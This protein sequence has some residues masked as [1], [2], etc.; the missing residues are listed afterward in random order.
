MSGRETWTRIRTVPWEPITERLGQASGITRDGAEQ[1]L[2][3]LVQGGC[4][5]IGTVRERRRG[6]G[7]ARAAVDGEAVP[8]DVPETA[9]RARGDAEL[10]RRLGR[11]HRRGD[12][13]GGR[14]RWRVAALRADAQGGGRVSTRVG[15]PPVRARARPLDREDRRPGHDDS[16]PG[17]D[18]TGE[19]ERDRGGPAFRGTRREGAC[20]GRQARVVELHRKRT[21]HRYQ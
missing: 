2:A 19:G 10:Q 3:Q 16:L 5:T 13:Q 8:A 14:C 6:R 9:R 11:A 1:Q 15:R 4:G 18:R 7:C 20:G 21:S 17:H 12:Q